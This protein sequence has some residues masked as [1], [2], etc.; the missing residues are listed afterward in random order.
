MSRTVHKGTA[1]VTGAA[2]G[3]G[4]AYAERLAADGFDTRT[5]HRV[6]EDIFEDLPKQQTIPRT[7]EPQD[8]AGVV[9]FLCS[10]DSSFVT[11]QTIAADGGQVRT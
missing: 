2:N 11:G 3:I 1:V 7:I 5:M 8:L 10:A 4:Q 9:S 6:N